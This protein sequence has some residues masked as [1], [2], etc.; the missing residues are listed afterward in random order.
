VI[1][2][3]YDQNSLSMEELLDDVGAETKRS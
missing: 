1:F 3:K 2:K